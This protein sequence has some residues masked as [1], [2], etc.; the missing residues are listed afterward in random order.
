MI[1]NL[2]YTSR[3]FYI[4]N[5]VRI[6]L[7]YLLSGLSAISLHIKGLYYLIHNLSSIIDKVDIYVRKKS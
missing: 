4:S 1:Q 3:D 7:I 5:L 2:I 6:R